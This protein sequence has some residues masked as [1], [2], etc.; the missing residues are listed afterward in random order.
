MNKILLITRPDHEVTTRYL[1]AWSDKIIKLADKKSIQVLD[2]KREKAN[3][4]ELQSRISKMKPLFIIFNGHG[5]DDRVAGYEDEIL[6]KAGSNERLLESKIVYAVSCRSA[7]ELGLK[8]VEAGAL[9]YIGYTGDFVFCHDDCKVSRPLED[10]IVKLFL[11]PSNQV[12][13]SL[14]KGNTS[15]DSSN[16]SKKFFLRNVQKLLS[17][18]APDGS[19][20]YAKFL[21]WNMKCQV[22]LGDQEAKLEI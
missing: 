14:I 12:A 22:C 2:L 15:G 13:I 19:A 11:E 17:S 16:R 9:A 20:Q 4:K 5:D 7:T 3:A 18:E 21:F 10:K 1:S 6:V 8:S